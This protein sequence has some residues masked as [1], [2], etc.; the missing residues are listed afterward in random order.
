MPPGAF[1]VLRFGIYR[2]FIGR[3]ERVTQVLIIARRPNFSK[4]RAED[5]QRPHERTHDDEKYAIQD[6]LVRYQVRVTIPGPKHPCAREEEP[7]R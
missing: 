7:P 6:P 1:S 3:P 4:V 5:G 2:A